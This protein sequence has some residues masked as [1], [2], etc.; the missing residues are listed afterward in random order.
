[1]S[2]GSPCSFPFQYQAS[3]GTHHP[4]VAIDQSQPVF[5]YLS[6]TSLSAQ[7]TDRFNNM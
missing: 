6:G 5:A 1:M 4:A 3:L 2:A 7:L